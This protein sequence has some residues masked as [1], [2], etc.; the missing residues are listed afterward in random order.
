MVI[1]INCHIP[2]LTTITNINALVIISSLLALQAFLE[3]RRKQQ[4]SRPQSVMFLPVYPL[5][6]C[7]IIEEYPFVVDECLVLLMNIYIVY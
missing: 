4:R 1:E 5:F 7:D 6:I 2:E 3:Q